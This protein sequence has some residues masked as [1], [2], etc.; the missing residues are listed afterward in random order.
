MNVPLEVPKWEG[1]LKDPLVKVSI[2]TP[3]DL[4][5]IIDG[6][7]RRNAVDLMTKAS[8]NFGLA[9]GHKYAANVVMKADKKKALLRNADALAVT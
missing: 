1:K 5:K 4:R 6:G 7:S 8:Q 2:R 3:K 9:D